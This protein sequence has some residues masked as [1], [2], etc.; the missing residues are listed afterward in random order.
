MHPSITMNGVSLELPN[1]RLLLQNLHFSIG[2]EVT[3]LVGANGVGKTTIARLLSGDLQPTHGQITRSGPVRYFSQREPQPN[4]PVYEYLGED[5]SWS[6]FGEQL[7]EGIDRDRSCQLLSGGQWMRVR[8]TKVIEEGFLILDEPTNDLDRSGR[9]ALLE[10]LKNHQSGIL[11]ISHDR[12][13][14]EL[15]QNVLELS[16][17]GLSKYGNGWASYE[18]AKRLERERLEKN[19]ERTKRERDQA[20]EERTL[21]L[22]RQ[23]KRN[24]KGALDAAKGGLP[25]IL[26]GA[27]KR[28]AEATT[29]KVSSDSLARAQ[30]KVH[31]AFEAYNEL[32]LDPVMYADLCGEEIPAQK[33]VCEASGFNILY[34]RWIFKKD[35]TFSW[36][37][38]ARIAI[39]GSNGSGKSTLLRA[40]TS[41]VEST[42]GEMKVGSLRTLF[43]DQKCAILDETKTIFENVR[44]VSNLHDKEI[45]NGLAKF[46]FFGDRVFQ[47]TH[48]LS[49][50]ERLRAALACGLL[51]SEKPQLLILDEPTNNLDLVN[52]EFLEN[53][54][55]GFKGALVLVSHD[56]RFLEECRI[57]DVLIL[58]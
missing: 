53:L 54:V 49:G 5:Y 44:E 21:H 3:A 16:N 4:I 39:K 24:R 45:R 50:G 30:E 34:D 10:V 20:E 48:S 18:E 25:K 57:E 19:L 15:S 28:N 11:L 46:L 43:L 17:L 8:L 40:L 42:K 32:K 51:R 31:A 23:E 13:C 35:L 38:N 47:P 7:L 2:P 37:G 52:V 1:G 14:L 6:K 29:G 36:R 22:E 55:S 41:S 26:L 56:E 27:R 12:E 9:Q 58:E 33:L